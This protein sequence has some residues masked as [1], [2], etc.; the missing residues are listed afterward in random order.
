MSTRILILDRIEVL[1]E[2]EQGFD[3]RT[4]KWDDV[5]VDGVHLSEVDFTKLTDNQLLSMFEI[6][7]RQ[8]HKMM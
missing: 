5:F 7:L 3:P 6:I 8:H 1:R 2:Y 4:M